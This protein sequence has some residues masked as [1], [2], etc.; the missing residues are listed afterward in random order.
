MKKL[1]FITFLLLG[2]TCSAQEYLRPSWVKK[3]PKPS[4]KTF[5][6][7]VTTAEGK[8][9]N[10][11]YVK[12]FSM[13]ILEGTW[14]MGVVVDT[15]ND[16]KAIEEDLTNAINMEPKLASLK[17]NKVCVYEEYPKQ[18]REVTI[19]L[20]VLWQIGD[21]EVDKVEFDDFNDCI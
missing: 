15:K 9:Y 21:H 11:A 13:A 20:F 18:T 6:Y 4:N 17:L 5:Y 3:T 8:D 10:E 1:F 16:L 2:I 19:R 7:K 14:R 12:A